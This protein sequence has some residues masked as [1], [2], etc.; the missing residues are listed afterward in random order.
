MNLKPN[1]YQVISE[2]ALF[3]ALSRAR[4]REGNS[5]EVIFGEPIFGKTRE[6]F[7]RVRRRW[8]TA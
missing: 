3:L 2:A 7:F 1:R 5:R 8:R 6:V 4:Q